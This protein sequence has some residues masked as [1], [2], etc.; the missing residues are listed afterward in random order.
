MILIHF[1][2]VLNHVEDER[3]AFDKLGNHVF[4]K[5]KHRCLVLCLNFEVLRTIVKWLIKSRVSNL[6]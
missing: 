5:W 4:C 3:V 1:K 2:D 6:C